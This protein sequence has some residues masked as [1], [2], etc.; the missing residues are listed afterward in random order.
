MA[1][2]HRAYLGYYGSKRLLEIRSLSVC[3]KVIG[4]DCASSFCGEDVDCFGC[5]DDVG[6][7]A[8]RNL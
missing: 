1:D 8:R 5:G 7:E 6:R 3:V 4:Y 2:A